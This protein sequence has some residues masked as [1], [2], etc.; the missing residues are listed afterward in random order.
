M[1]SSEKDID[2][3]AV[4]YLIELG[5]SMAQDEACMLKHKMK[6]L[7]HR[8][9]CSTPCKGSFQKRALFSA[10]VL[11]SETDMCDVCLAVF[12]LTHSSL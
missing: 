1:L 2:S 11:F 5:C 6:Q 4:L 8:K 3:G 9:T 7:K 12:C 10:C